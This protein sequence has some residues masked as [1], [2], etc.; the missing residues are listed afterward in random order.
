MF[1]LIG[2]VIVLG[3]II[4]GYL[5]EHGKLMVLYQ[6][7]EL[8]IIGGAAIGSCL[9]ANPLP[10]LKGVFT[11]LLGLLKPDPFG[12]AFYLDNLK[13]LSDIFQYARR[14]G[15]AKLEADIED[16]AQSEIFK[17]YPQFLRDHHALNFFCD[18]V[19]TS[20]SGGTDALQLDQ[21]ME[22]DIEVHHKEHHEPVAALQTTADALP[23]L[24]IVAAVLG[25]VITMGA[26]GGP[27]D[28]L[29]HKVAAALVGTFLGILLC[30]GFV[31]PMAANMSKRADAYG[32]YL[33]FLR[34][35]ILSFV[36][37]NPPAIAVEFA[38]RTIA[39]LIRPGFVETEKAIKGASAAAA[40]AAAAEV[41]AP[42]EAEGS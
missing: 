1:V 23:G 41:A 39:P 16:P 40:A 26:L 6:P 10:V 33:Q 12:K 2:S 4:G 27:P 32:Q 25:V 11:G 9:V 13:M 5:M 20:I 38:R 31:G 28:E 36:Q 14:S 29:G 17:K 22:L 34:M 24:G 15:L 8:L 19:R 7:A 21:L 35:G 18:T 37:G 30:Y 42:A 3:A